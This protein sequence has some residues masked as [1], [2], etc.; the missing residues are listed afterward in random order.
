MGNELSIGTDEKNMLDVEK[1]A[2]VTDLAPYFNTGSYL[3]PH[4]D[5]VSLLVMEQQMDVQNEISRVGL[6][7]RAILAKSQD[8]SE[9]VRLCEPLV[10]SLLC[11][12]E[13]KL[14]SPVKGTSTFAQTYASSAPKD[15]LGRSLSELDL[16]TRV[17]KY[18][19]SPLVYSESFMSL[20]DEVREVVWTQ[21]R[22]GLAGTTAFAHISAEEK[23]AIL[24]ILSAT[25]PEFKR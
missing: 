1:G 9:L 22:D 8:K 5:I 17:L 23:K 16:Q 14:E 25:V 19:C 3:T 6:R 7:S 21:L 2:N 18:R 11:V 20:P 4:S 12:G 10:R 13:A 15:S 24:E